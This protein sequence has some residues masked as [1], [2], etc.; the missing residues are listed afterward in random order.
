MEALGR[1]EDEAPLVPGPLLTSSP[2]VACQ[3]GATRT[4]GRT[5][6]RP[7]PVLPSPAA[8][9]SDARRMLCLSGLS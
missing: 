9:S 3:T 1:E 6:P 7:V 4:E 2:A 8:A 5:A